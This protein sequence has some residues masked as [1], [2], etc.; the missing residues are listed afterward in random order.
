MRTLDRL[1]SYAIVFSKALDWIAGAGLVAMF[2]LATAD[3]F[4][5]KVFKHPIPGGI[6]VIAFLGVVVTAFSMAFTYVAKGHIQVEIL[7]MKISQR[8]QMVLSCLVGFLG[9]VLFV[10]LAWTSV[11]YGLVLQR[12]GEVSMTQ[13][14]PFY[15]FIY[16]IA[17][18]AISTAFLLL[19][20]LIKN[21]TRVVKG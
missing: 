1:E 11:D 2:A 12:S 6:E 13:R 10:I 7:T 19:I 20:D 3:I 15:P 5:V 9:L 4:G 16:G 21:F 14:I 17:V 8:S 18:C